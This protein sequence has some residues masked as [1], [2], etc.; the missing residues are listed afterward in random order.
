MHEGDVEVVRTHGVDAAH[1]R[2]AGR[3]HPDQAPVP[4][5]GAQRMAEGQPAQH[6]PGG[7]R[8]GVPE[9]GHRSEGTQG[10]EVLAAVIG[11]HEQPLRTR[12]RDDADQRLTVRQD[13]SQRAR[14]GPQPVDEPDAGALGPREVGHVVEPLTRL[15]E[16]ELRPQVGEEGVPAHEHTVGP[17]GAT[18]ARFVHRPG[19][20][21]HVTVS[22]CHHLIASSGNDCER[23]A[24]DHISP[25][26]RPTSVPRAATAALVAALGT[27]ALGRLAWRSAATVGMP[28][29]PDDVVATVALAAGTLAGLALCAGCLLLLVGATARS[30]GRSWRWAERAA[31][32]LTPALLRRVLAVSVTTG[33]GLAATGGTAVA[34][35]VDVG[36]QVTSPADP[37][38]DVPADVP[39]EGPVA[40]VPG[41]PTALPA[42]AVRTGGAAPAAA[43]ALSATAAPVAGTGA[44]PRTV[45]VRPGDCLWDIAATYLAPGGGD[46]EIATAWPLLYAANRDVIGPDPDLILPGQVLVL[47]EGL[48]A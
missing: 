38:A 47:P 18:D 29:V 20:G 13:E 7:R 45:V 10:D 4:R 46:A 8:R 28:P 17:T 40:E 19:T 31:R 23:T 6:H 12:V 16:V 48:P 39:T 11:Q 42:D 25:G 21:S 2:A 9:A 32:H 5:D 3:A 37:A 26:G 1:H 14:V 30:L 33:L 34:E 15:R 24:M 22:V 27:M 35:E 43:V 36:W 41:A 44:T